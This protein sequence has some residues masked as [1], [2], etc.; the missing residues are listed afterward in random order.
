ML[1]N[2]PLACA[3]EA[4]SV[5]QATK[6]W[7]WI[8]AVLVVACSNTD[9]P[10][11]EF[12]GGGFIFNYRL[13]EADY[14]F[15]VKPVRRIPAGTILEAQFENPSGGEPIVIRETAEFGRLQYVF[16]TPP[17]RGVKA[18]REYHAELRLLDPADKHVLAIY[19]RTFRSDVDQSMLPERPPVVGPGY[20]S[21][22]RKADK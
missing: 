4:D 7:L 22:P 20:Q 19:S 8:A 2:T 15:V 5:T 16:R 11:I 3:L 1:G 18:N 21:A 13:A 12:I 6:I 10:Y 17:V 14:G 9:K